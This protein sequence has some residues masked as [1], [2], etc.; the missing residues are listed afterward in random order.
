[1]R[2]KIL[3]MLNLNKI[4]Q[5]LLQYIRFQN[6]E[7]V[8][9]PFVESWVKNDHLGFEITYNYQGTFHKYRPDFIIKFKNGEHLILEVKGQDTKKDQAKRKY[10]N[11]WVKAINTHGGFG[12]WHWDVSFHPNDLEEKISKHYKSL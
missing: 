2:R 4:V 9:H 8:K 11:E 1:M 10:L 3:I 7:L 5:H 12:G 6:V